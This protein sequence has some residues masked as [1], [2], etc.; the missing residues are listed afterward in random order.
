MLKYV[1]TN[2]HNSV[3]WSWNNSGPWSH[4]SSIKFLQ[5]E[6]RHVFHY[7]F[8]DPYNQT[9]WTGPWISH[10]SFYF[11]FPHS[12]L[13]FLG[14]FSSQ[15]KTFLLQL[16]SLTLTPNPESIPFFPLLLYFH[17]DAN[18]L[19]NL[20]LQTKLN[21]YHYYPFPQLISPL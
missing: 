7:R 13:I 10:I 17:W 14:Q 2:I 5:P 18:S 1:H 12:S 15:F 9:F 20:W 16:S 19:A 8:L 3:P 4:I 21:S 6:A 11:L